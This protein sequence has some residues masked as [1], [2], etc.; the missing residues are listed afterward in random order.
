M[1]KVTLLVESSEEKK[2]K[3][4]DKD[5]K[6]IFDY[7]ILNIN[8]YMILKFNI[9]NNRISPAK[10]RYD[11]ISFFF[12][13]ITNALCI[14]R[15]FTVDFTTVA[16]STVNKLVVVP[17]RCYPMITIFALTV[18]FILSFVH[19]HNI[20]SFIL[21]IETL[22]RSINIK[23]DIKPFVIWNRIYIAMVFIM[24]IFIL[25]VF[26]ST[27]AYLGTNDRILDCFN[28]VVCILT[29]INSIM[30][31]R[32]IVLLRKYVDEWVKMLMELKQER[33]NYEKCI[34]LFETY[35]DILA[36]H[37]LYKTIFQTVVS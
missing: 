24:N 15:L 34:S 18:T 16:T 32:M 5:I 11:I 21:K 10:R 31:I 29:D 22:N 35:E 2:N 26:Y 1:G 33:E 20:V 23:K 36:A 7:P 4:L 14:Y 37:D 3:K 13:F 12:T 9:K 19:K 28:D 6:K 30:S 17:A 25:G 8:P 27:F